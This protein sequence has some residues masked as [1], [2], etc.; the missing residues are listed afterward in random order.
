[1]V[2]DIDLRRA[3]RS[4]INLDNNNYSSDLSLGDEFAITE[5]FDDFVLAEYIDVQDGFIKD[6][7]S[8]LVYTKSS[9]E[10]W[11]KARIIMVG[12][13]VK[14]CK[15]GDLVV[16]PDDKGLKTGFVK[17]KDPLTKENKE[18]KYGFFTNDYKLFAKIQKV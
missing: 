9:K 18:T 14:F 16:F 1:M 15:V 7:N 2:A 12:P 3:R 6:E 8:D 13:A 11:R 5:L 17:Y 4:E 10:V